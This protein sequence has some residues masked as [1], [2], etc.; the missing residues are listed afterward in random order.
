[1]AVVAILS[2]CVSCGGGGSENGLA[3][4]TSQTDQSGD[5]N[6]DESPSTPADDATAPYWCSQPPISDTWGNWGGTITHG[7]ADDPLCEYNITLLV[8]GSSLLKESDNLLCETYGTMQIDT[9]YVGSD[10]LFSCE[11]YPVTF[12]FEALFQT[13]QNITFDPDTQ[14]GVL[15]AD[16]PVPMGFITGPKGGPDTLDVGRDDNTFS[17]PFPTVWSFA[18]DGATIT[19]PGPS[20]S[21]T[22]QRR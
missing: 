18:V 20:H 7:N 17:L 10:P 12:A 3:D 11:E 9:T 13:L 5:P 15:F 14:Q 8:D 6:T 4:N 2:L 21:G 1:M 19:V 22:L 16:L